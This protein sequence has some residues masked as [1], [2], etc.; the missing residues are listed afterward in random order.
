MTADYF[1]SSTTDFSLFSFHTSH[2]SSRTNDNTNRNKTRQ[3]Q[4]QS[5]GAD[6]LGGGI[7]C[8]SLYTV[9]TVRGTG[10]RVATLYRRL[11]SQ[12]TYCAMRM[13]ADRQQKQRC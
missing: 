6:A 8:Y 3:Q 5:T 12:T 9:H 2:L 4:Q 1:F 11:I 13:Q 10:L 7:I